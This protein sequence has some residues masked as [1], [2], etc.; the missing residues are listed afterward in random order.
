MEKMFKYTGDCP[1]TGN[2]I[3]SVQCRQCEWFFRPGTYTFIWCSHPVP[4]RAEE[5][6]NGKLPASKKTA[7]GK[8]ARPKRKINGNPKQIKPA[9]TPKKRGRPKKAK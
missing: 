8:P 4:E 1:Y 3:D 2:A 6:A 5:K 9:T 7:I